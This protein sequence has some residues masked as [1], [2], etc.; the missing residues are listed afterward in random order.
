V[1]DYDHAHHVGN[2]GDVW[3]HVGW[4]ALLAANKRRRVA[5]VETHAGSGAYRLAPGGEGAAG[6]GRLRAAWADR[7]TGSGA[8]DRY[9]ARIAKEPAG[10]YPG[11]PA[12][13]VSALGHAD[14]WVGYE[15]DD[16]AVAALRSAVGG[17]DRVRIVHASGWDAPELGTRVP[18]ADGVGVACVDPQ[19]TKPED[20]VRAV[21]ATR[22][23]AEAGRQV[24]LWY[25]IKRWTRPNLLLQR[26]RDAGVAYV[27]LDLLWTPMELDK[28]RMVGAGVLLAGVAPSV[29]L[30]LHAAAPVVGAALAT[31]DGRWSLRTTA[32]G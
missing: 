12:L 31:V 20:W 9:L 26:L 17:D 19:Y 8:V 27:A 3:K 24:L 29:V 11:S 5:I 16:G 28:K 22:T 7:S 1:S 23:A 25:P 15:V 32:N 6:I 14:R 2:P 21:D 30:E 18:E 4:L 10:T 13:A